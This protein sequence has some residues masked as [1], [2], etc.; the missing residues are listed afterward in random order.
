[1]ILHDG[2]LAIMAK[3]V[4]GLG[5]CFDFNLKDGLKTAE[6]NGH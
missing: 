5:V 2:I 1:M 4:N 3:M 6:I